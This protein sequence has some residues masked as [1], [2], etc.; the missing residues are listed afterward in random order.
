MRV[1]NDFWESQD[2]MV[3]YNTN[4]GEDV[5]IYAENCETKNIVHEL[6]LQQYKYSSIII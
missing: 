3:R 2:E 5:F 4:G 6:T 1:E